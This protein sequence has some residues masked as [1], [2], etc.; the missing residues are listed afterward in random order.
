[1]LIRAFVKDGKI[2]FEWGPSDPFNYDRWIVRWS[3]AGGTPVAPN[4]QEDVYLDGRGRDRMN[5]YFHWPMPD[6]VI[7]SDGRR[8]GVSFV[9]E[10][11]DGEARQSWTCPIFVRL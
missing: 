3:V 10:G 9:V 4:A 5:G 11:Y 1:M 8:V 7:G 6:N 2:V